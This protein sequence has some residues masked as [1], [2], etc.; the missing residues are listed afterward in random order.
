[1]V[2]IDSSGINDNDLVRVNVWSNYPD[3]CNFKMTNFLSYTNSWST[4]S[5]GINNNDLAG[6]NELTYKM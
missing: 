3:K 4:E 6:V 2:S 1:M 5:S